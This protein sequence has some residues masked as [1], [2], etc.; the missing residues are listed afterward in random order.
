MTAFSFSRGIAGAAMDLCFNT[1]HL[2]GIYETF[3]K[4]GRARGRDGIHPGSLGA[5]I[6][7]TCDQIT[8]KLHD[9]SYRFTRYREHLRLKGAGK[10]PRRLSIP[11]ARDR[12]ALRALAEYLALVSPNH[13]TK[14]PQHC[15]GD[16][17]KTLQSTEYDAFVRLDVQN[18][19]PSIQHKRL[20]GALSRPSTAPEVRAIVMRAVRTPTAPDRERPLDRNLRG[21]PQ[22][23]AI[24]NI[25][26][27]FVAA[28][29]DQAVQALSPCSYFRYV[30]DVILFCPT[31]KVSYF[32]RE[33]RRVF[34]EY[35]LITHPIGPQYK[36]KV[37]Y[38]KDG[39][40]Y[41][42]YEFIGGEITVRKKSVHQLEARI[43][44]TFTAYKRAIEAS[45]NDL[46]AERISEEAARRCLREVNLL[47][48][49]FTFKRTERGWIQYYRQMNDYKLLN[50]LDA[51]VRHFTKRFGLPPFFEP[52]QFIRAYWA[53]RFPDARNFGYIPN[54]DKFTT[55]QKR[56]VVE[57][58]IGSSRAQGMT[59]V[60]VEEKFLG[61]A[62][63][64]SS[65]FEKDVGP[66]S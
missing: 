28:Q 16:V 53:A 30:D 57:D 4:K 34:L 66:L 48:T 29:V 13:R 50:R 62:K 10:P 8:K 7:R 18:F 5:D 20:E 40:D 61:L 27:E 45:R 25:L 31:A 58:I 32:A 22:G 15:A 24:S 38:L 59:D 1:E 46:D 14:I 11:T 63:R 9:G 2:V 21:V 42:G 23:L 12:I 36:S 17:Y 35:G 64:F 56:G 37:G 47:V 52:R 19:Y 3:V 65:D 26:A 41:L 54:W 49:G 60:E 43:A 44:R 51:T 39:F 6:E 33:A 55:E